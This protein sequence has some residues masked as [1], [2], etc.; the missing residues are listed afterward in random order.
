MK[1]GDKVVLLG[2]AHD[3]VMEDLREI[4]SQCTFLYDKE[5]RLHGILD[6][7]FAE[8][9]FVVSQFKNSHEYL[10]VHG[11]PELEEYIRQINELDKPIPPNS[12]IELHAIDLSTYFK[13]FLLLAKAAL[14]KVVPLYSYRSNDT[15][16]T[17]GD[18]GDRLVKSIKQNRHLRRQSDML[19]LIEQ[20][21]KEWLD[22]L[23]DL[24]DEYAHYSSLEQY[25]NFWLSTNDLGQNKL[26]GIS[27]FRRPS[28][29]ING[30]T[31]DALEYVLS[32]K[33]NMIVFLREFL[34]L[35]E[36]TADRRPK[37]YL[38]CEWCRYAFARWSKKGP[39]QLIFT[40]ERIET[41]VVDRDKGYGF[42]I[43][44]KCGGQTETDIEFWG[45]ESL[46]M[47]DPKGI[48]KKAQP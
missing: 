28:L 46:D 23:I 13:S 29:A 24:R 31:V 47:I 30:K 42:L 32:I 18:K 35:C 7:A 33:A 34:S 43:C 14:D 6:E 45:R 21:K 20:A 1:E 27:Q 11:T 3:F 36:F 44:P 17:F 39:R 19:N 40:T 8:M 2:A 37:A 15:L 9:A 12:F 48:M 10:L 4:T 41:Q 26:V 25:V 38:K 22:T 5:A 16:K